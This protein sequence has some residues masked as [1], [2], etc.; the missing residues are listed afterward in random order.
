[1]RSEKAIRA[2]RVLQKEMKSWVGLAR[3]IRLCN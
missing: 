1:M 3:L 2:F